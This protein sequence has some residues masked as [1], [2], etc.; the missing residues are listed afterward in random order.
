MP[1]AFPAKSLGQ[2]LEEIKLLHS[3][4]KPPF[5]ILIYPECI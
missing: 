1:A 5:E 3:L 4:M 2:S